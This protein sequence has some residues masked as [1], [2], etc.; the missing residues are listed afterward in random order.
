MK[1]YVRLKIRKMLEF[2]TTLKLSCCFERLPG[3][4]RGIERERERGWGG[5]KA[6]EEIERGGER[7]RKGGVEERDRKEGVKEKKK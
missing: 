1:L 3:H 6:E 2:D 7:E 5:L 4:E